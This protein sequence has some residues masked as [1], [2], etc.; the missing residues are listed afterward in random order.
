MALLGLA[1]L[2]SLGCAGVTGRVVVPLEAGD[3]VI[4]G[5]RIVAVCFG[6]DGQVR[7]VKLY[8]Q[9]RVFA[10]Q[11]TV[12]GLTAGTAIGAAAGQPAAGAVV[13]GGTG[14]LTDLVAAAR[15]LFG[16]GQDPTPSCGPEA[17]L[18]KESALSDAA[19]P[20]PK[21]SPPSPPASSSSSSS[22]PEAPDVTAFE[23]PVELVA[24]AP[25]ARPVRGSSSWPAGPLALLCAAPMPERWCR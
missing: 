9:S 14:L 1:F 12:L 10:G 15:D 3:L 21:A 23:L 5:P 8:R 13:G 4:Q 25:P 18:R 20:A 2:A 7:E 24:G 22:T 11:N 16:T 19:A 6:V 17:S